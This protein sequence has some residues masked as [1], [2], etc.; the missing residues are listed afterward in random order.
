[1]KKH[2]KATERR[3]S[4]VKCEEM[5]FDGACKNPVRL[6]MCDCPMGTVFIKRLV[7]PERSGCLA[8]ATS[9]G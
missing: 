7:P 4:M 1:M 3:D 5:L 8:I 9:H 2:V 6:S